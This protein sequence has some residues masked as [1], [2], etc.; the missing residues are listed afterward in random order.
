MIYQYSIYAAFWQYGFSGGYCRFLRKIYGHGLHFFFRFTDLC[1]RRRSLR[2]NVLIIVMHRK[3]NNKYNFFMIMII[4]R[5]CVLPAYAVR[6][7]RGI[8]NSGCPVL[9]N[10]CYFYVKKAYL[11]E[12]TESQSLSK[13]SALSPKSTNTSHFLRYSSSGYIFL[14]FLISS[15]S[16]S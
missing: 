1:V 3:T 9:K 7:K 16:C 10:S 5:Y 14:L 15:S 12:V 2:I 6:K 4:R 11:P 13:S 8:R